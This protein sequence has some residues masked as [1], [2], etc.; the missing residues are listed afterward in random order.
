MDR[1]ARAIFGWKWQMFPLLPWQYHTLHMHMLHNR[2]VFPEHLSDCGRPL[3]SFVWWFSNL[4]F[5]PDENVICRFFLSIVTLLTSILF[6][7]YSQTGLYCQ[8]QSSRLQTD[9]LSTSRPL[10]SFSIIYAA[11]I[12][13]NDRFFVRALEDFIAAAARK[14][15]IDWWCSDYTFILL[16]TSCTYRKYVRGGG[17]QFHKQQWFRHKIGQNKTEN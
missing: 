15:P 4:F 2:I 5:R 11:I 8:R 12:L 16:P 3:K 7:T 14:S 13:K 6:D 9:L 1:W 10:T 17:R